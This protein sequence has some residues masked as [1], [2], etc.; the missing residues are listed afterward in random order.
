MN[1]GSAWTFTSLQ[2]TQVHAARVIFA[3]ES[4]SSVRIKGDPIMRLALFA[5][6]LALTACE[7][8]QDVAAPPASPPA[9]AAAEPLAPEI[10]NVEGWQTTP[11]SHRLISKTTPDFSLQ[12]VGGGSITRER[13]RGRWTIL[14][15]WNATLAGVEEETRYLRA[16]NSAVD[17]DPDLD[18]LTIYLKLDAA[19]TD[20][21]K[22]FANNGGDPWP[23]LVD[24]GETDDAFGIAVLPAYLLIGPDLTIRAWRDALSNDPDGIKPVIRGVAE[25]RKQVASPR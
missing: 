16:L 23:T 13:L 9:P 21:G 1:D 18:L 11:A 15:F 4:G 8:P 14:G 10:A 22:W 6:A 5:A 12:K 19:G 17:Q 24:E 7:K 20:I 2:L 3:P 25:I